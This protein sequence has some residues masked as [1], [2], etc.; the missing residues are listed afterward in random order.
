MPDAHAATQQVG[1][2][3]PGAVNRG[4]RLRVF[5]GRPDVGHEIRRALVNPATNVVEGDVKRKLV[6]V[7]GPEGMVADAV[8]AAAEIGVAVHTEE[9]LF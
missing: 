1:G 4:A 2:F 8:S 9:F 6:L 7:C 3:V 5:E